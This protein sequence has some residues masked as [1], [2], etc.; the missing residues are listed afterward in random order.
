[1]PS[2]K[3]MPSHSPSAGQS[4]VVTRVS[5]PRSVRKV[6]APMAGEDHFAMIAATDRKVPA[7]SLWQRQIRSTSGDSEG[8]SSNTRKVPVLDGFAEECVGVVGSESTKITLRGT[9]VPLQPLPHECL[10]LFP[11]ASR[12][13]R[14]GSRRRAAWP[15]RWRRPHPSPPLRHRRTVGCSSS[16]MTATSLIQQHPARSRAEVAQPAITFPTI[17]RCIGRGIRRSKNTVAL[18]KKP[19]TTVALRRNMA[20]TPAIATRRGS[21]VINLTRGENF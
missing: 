18:F 17:I 15:A 10:E 9:L 8:L 1:M 13:A 3:R 6:S 19:G 20:S 11:R 12:G 4:I 21:I 16:L 14:E 7:R 5:G 2:E